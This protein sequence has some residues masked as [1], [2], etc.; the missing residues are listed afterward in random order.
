MLTQKESFKL[1]RRDML[2]K[3][4]PSNREKLDLFRGKVVSFGPSSGWG[5]R[6]ADWNNK[7]NDLSSDTAAA[8]RFSQLVRINKHRKVIGSSSSIQTSS[9]LTVIT[10]AIQVESTCVTSSTVDL[11]P[12]SSSPIP[13][14][15]LFISLRSLRVLV[16]CLVFQKVREIAYWKR[17]D[18]LKTQLLTYF[19]QLTKEQ[20]SQLG[21][22]IRNDV[23]TTAKHETLVK[24]TDQIHQIITDLVELLAA[25]GENTALQVQAQC[26]IDDLKKIRRARQCPSTDDYGSLSDPDDHDFFAD[27]ILGEGDVLVG[28]VE[29]WRTDDEIAD[30]YGYVETCKGKNIEYESVGANMDDLISYVFRYAP[31]DEITNPLQIPEEIRVETRKWFK[32]LPNQTQKKKYVNAKGEYTGQ[33]K[34]WDFEEQHSLVIIKRTYGVQY[35]RLWAKFLQTLPIRDLHHMAQLDLNNHTNIGNIRGLIPHLVAESRESKWKTFKPA[36]GQ[37]V[38]TRDKFTDKQV[39]KMVYPPARCL[40]KITMRKFDLDKI[41]GIGFWYLDG[42]TC[43]AVITKK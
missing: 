12:V 39:L 3:I 36:A 9:S 2:N 38:K 31:P 30:K 4:S 16:M 22:L 10:K 15:P 37:A 21:Q 11:P 35:F 20:G 17:T 29:E 40:L 1:V 19:F 8:V 32:S 34:S 33:I 7:L 43:E 28:T 6:L 27:V 42:K 26:K 5:L 14:A 24:A 25:Q 13:S 41:Q 23:G 18:E